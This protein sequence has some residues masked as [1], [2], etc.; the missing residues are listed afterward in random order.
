M[1]LRVLGC[2]GRLSPETRSPGFL[3]DGQLLVD[4]GTIGSAL[5]ESELA[6]VRWLV[7]S[8]A[9]LDHVKEIPSFLLARHD[10]QMPPLTVAGLPDSL[11]SLRGHLFNDFLWPDFSRIGEPP[12]L[13]FRPLEPGRAEALG[14][15]RVT[16]IDVCHTVRCAG[17]LIEGPDAAFAYV[18]DS[19]ATEEIWQAIAANPRVQT[20]VL[21]IS[22]PDRFGRDAEATGH[23]TPTA[24]QADLRKIG[25]EMEV[26][27]MHMHPKHASEILAEID[28]LELNAEL[29]EQSAVY[30][31]ADK[32]PVRRRKVL[33]MDEN[34]KDRF[35]KDADGAPLAGAAAPADEAGAKIDP[36]GTTTVGAAAPFGSGK[37]SDGDYLVVIHGE[38]LGR[39]YEIRNNPI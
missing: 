18:T 35:P 6:G 39:R 9:H 1:D 5:A 23:Y 14:P 17:Y 11:D 29:M 20:V 21:D 27:T 15:Y 7:L 12:A 28:R 16:A 22:L 2:F 31:I 13:S 34:D 30:V 24:A 26:L 25:R 32:S 10:A 8:H 19:G 37:R 3:V 36:S 33:L 4:G 38:N